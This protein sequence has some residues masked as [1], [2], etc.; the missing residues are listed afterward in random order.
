MFSIV[1]SEKKM[2]FTYIKWNRGHLRTKPFNYILIKLAVLISCSGIFPLD[3]VIAVGSFTRK[4]Y[5]IDYWI[6]MKM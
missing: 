6:L 4:Y 1:V 5:V 3:G 2:T